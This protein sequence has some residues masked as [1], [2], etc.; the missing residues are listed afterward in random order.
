MTDTTIDGLPV[1][2]ADFGEASSL[3]GG[4]GGP[5]GIGGIQVP[6]GTHLVISIATHGTAVLVG[7]GESF[8]R[9]VLETATG[10]SLADQASYRTA[11]GLAMTTNAGQLYLAA[12]PLLALAESSMAAADKARFESDVKP[13]LASLD[14]FLET[15]TVDAS[16]L[17]VRLVLT[18]R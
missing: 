2:L 16:G 8:P 1:T 17:R 13:Y 18:V 15:T 4:T 6:P 9:H 5:S 12:A 7:N 11:L 14:A 10:A 3:V